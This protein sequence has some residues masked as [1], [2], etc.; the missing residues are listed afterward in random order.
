MEAD[1]NHQPLSPQRFLERS[2]EV[3]P[4]KT[5]LVDGERNW[6]YAELEAEVELVAD[7]LRSSGVEPGDRI[8]YLCR[9]VAELLIAHYAVPLAGGVLV[10]LNTRLSP[11]E[12]AW[13]SEHSGA[14]ML[15]VDHALEPAIAAVSDLPAPP[16]TVAVGGEVSGAV[17]YEEFRAR[18]GA[19]I[20]PRHTLDEE[21]TIS[22]NYT[23]GTTGRPKGVMYTHRG[24]Y[25]N[26]FG[27]IVHSGLDAGTV[28]LWTLPMFHC[29]G[30]CETWAVT[31]VGGTHVC[32]PAVRGEAIW[33]LIDE[34]GVTHLSGAPA[35]MST[36]VAAPEAHRLARPLTVTTAGAAP[37]PGT[38]RRLEE[39]GAKVIHVYGLTEVYGP[40]SV[41][42]WQP[43]WEDLEPR[44]RAAKLARQGVGMVHAD[45]VRVVDEEMDDVPADGETVGELVLRG[46]GVMKGYYRDP[47]ATDEAFRGGWFHSGDLGV[48][49]PDGYAEVRD[50]AKDIV[51]SGGENI[52]TIEVEHV[53]L[54][55][56]AVAEAAVIGVPDARWGE[57]PVAF[58]VVG[59]DRGP[60]EEAE[61][62]AH[63]RDRLARFKVPDR[64]RFVSALPR[65]STGKVQKF[66]LRAMAA[67]VAS[68]EPDGAGGEVA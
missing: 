34:L 18:R 47:D 30:W 38:I 5:A 43:G 41:C 26:A 56:P 39:L 20:G 53:L 22:I 67:A 42:E 40:Y 63:V 27:E 13:I 33:R 23:S 14:R 45:R 54:D 52:S 3:F 24:A 57:R 17:P 36:I 59:A 58:V 61:L 44:E 46:N 68:P 2:A 28:H 4:T 66:E 60:V 12:V 37:D 50:R 48:M 11:A 49:H 10:A 62:R 9:N 15:F 35:V 51:I 8:A 19:T 21:D 29:N 65:T 32:L 6:S 25:L 64:V 16:E 1:A 31:A 55:H 7:A